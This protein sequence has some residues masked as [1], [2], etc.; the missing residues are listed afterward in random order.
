M[1][2]M[3]YL[4]SLNNALE[5]IA[6][7]KYPKLKKIKSFLSNTSSN[8]FV[9]MSG[10]GSSIV[11]YFDTKKACGI[12]YSQYKRKFTRHWCIESKTI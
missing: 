11:A 2:E 8:M 1:F 7:K 12:A 6:F 5:K 4:K 3:K 9:R 10:S